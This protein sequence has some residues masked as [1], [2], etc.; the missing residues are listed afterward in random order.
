MNN[1]YLSMAL[2]GLTIALPLGHVHKVARM[3]AVTPV[4]EEGPRGMLGVV[5]LGG[6]VVPVF[7]PRVRFGLES[8][9]LDQGDHIVFAWARNRLVGLW[10]DEAGEVFRSAS[11]LAAHGADRTAV[12]PGE[13][14]WKDLRGIT[15]VA[16]LNEGLAVIRDLDAFLSEEDERQL[17]A[18]LERLDAEDFGREAEKEDAR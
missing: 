15:G 2:G 10:V 5:N 16:S 18:A 3:V 1:A 17:N 7:D 11:G 8:R 9:E 13:S 6:R 4:G 14:V 12:T